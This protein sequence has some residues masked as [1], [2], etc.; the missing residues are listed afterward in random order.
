MYLT[1]TVPK[2]NAI[3]DKYICQLCNTEHDTKLS[4]CVKIF[5]LLCSFH[6]T[7]IKYH[8]HLFYI[9]LQKIKKTLPKHSSSLY[10]VPSI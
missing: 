7:N 10:V 9:M 2:L 6:I 4:G 8:Y 5:V 1:C 3:P